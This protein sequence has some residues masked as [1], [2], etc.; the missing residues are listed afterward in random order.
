M[1]AEAVSM[2]DVRLRE[3]Q[4]RFVEDP[5][6]IE[7]LVRE[8]ERRRDQQG[9]CALGY[10]L[11]DAREPG[12]RVKVDGHVYVMSTAI[13]PHQGRAVWCSAC[14]SCVDVH[15]VA[16]RRWSK[17]RDASHINVCPASEM[18]ILGVYDWTMPEGLLYGRVLANGGGFDVEWHRRASRTTADLVARVTNVYPDTEYVAV[19]QNGS[20]LGVCFRMGSAP[21]AGATFS[22]SFDGD[23]DAVEQERF[24]RPWRA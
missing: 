17:H 22:M 2:S 16:S 11:V 1:D 3:M 12:W 5:S 14:N 10:H 6:A 13:R 8:L 24:E 23:A 20:G 7:G 18:T 19:S 15:W 4:R 21:C 9:L